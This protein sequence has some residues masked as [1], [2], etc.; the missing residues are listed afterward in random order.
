MSTKNQKKI[1]KIN[2]VLERLEKKAK[3]DIP[4]ILEGHKDKNALQS[5][6]IFGDVILTKT[7]GKNFLNVLREVEGKKKSEVILLLD[8]DRRGK[9]WTQRLRISLERIKIIPNLFFWNSIFR[10]VGRDI[11]DIEGFVTFFNNLCNK[12]TSRKV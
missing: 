8:F 4:I 12:S 6:G 10:L 3:Q 7:Q 5:L 9:E 2:K 11:K 1:E